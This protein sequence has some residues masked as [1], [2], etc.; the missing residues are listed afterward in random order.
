MAEWFEA[1]EVRDVA[2]GERHV[3][4]TPAGLIIIVNLDGAFYALQDICTHD[5]GILSDGPMINNEL[6]CPRHG[7]R[8]DI[9]TGEAMCAPAYEPVPTFPVEIRQGK[10]CIRID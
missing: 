6:V 2:P 9:K 7:A 4:Q 5:G 1:C 3:V 8:F 10:I